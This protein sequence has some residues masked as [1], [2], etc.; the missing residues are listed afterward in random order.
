MSFRV[1][2]FGIWQPSQLRLSGMHPGPLLRDW[3]CHST[4][5]PCWHLHESRSVFFHRWLQQLPHVTVCDDMPQHPSSAVRWSAWVS[6]LASRLH[7]WLRACHA[8]RRWVHSLHHRLVFARHGLLERIARS[9]CCGHPSCQQELVLCLSCW[10]VLCQRL[11]ESCCLPA[12][13]LFWFVCIEHF[14]HHLS[15]GFW[16]HCGSHCFV[17]PM[18]GWILLSRHHHIS[19]KHDNVV[20]V[21]CRILLPHRTLQ[22]VSSHPVLPGQVLSC[23]HRNRSQLPSWDIQSLIWRVCSIGWMQT[24]RCWHVLS[25]SLYCAHRPLQPWLLLS[26][27]HYHKLAVCVLLGTLSHWLVWP[28]T[29]ALP[30]WHLSQRFG[31]PPTQRLHCVSCHTI[32]SPR[33]CLAD[34]VSPRLLLPHSV[35]RP[36]RLSTRHIQQCF[37]QLQA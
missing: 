17:L 10:V 32:L 26:H 13:L 25:R 27:Q 29:G 31:R 33:L 20:C 30:S 24:M 9:S 23:S 6:V 5:V 19:C 37:G 18:Q 7:H 21:P 14:Q 22:P 1:I 35:W 12:W 28:T 3:V 34:S 36:N 4:C 8:R 2:L 15:R 16:W 11:C